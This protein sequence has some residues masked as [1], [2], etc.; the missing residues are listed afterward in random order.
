MFPDTTDVCLGFVICVL[1]Y[2]LIYQDPN[3]ED[4][5]KLS[6]NSKALVWLVTIGLAVFVMN[7]NETLPIDS[8][9]FGSTELPATS[10]EPF[11]EPRP[12][13]T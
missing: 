10:T 6:P 3:A 7:K 5:K 2:W 9:S 12:T 8:N 11:W 4:A 13:S 1:F